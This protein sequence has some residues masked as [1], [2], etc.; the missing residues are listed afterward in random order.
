MA[1]KIRQEVITAMCCPR[2]GSE[3]T[4]DNILSE[5]N[6]QFIKTTYENGNLDEV[7]T[8]AKMVSDQLPQ[9]VISG[10]T[11]ALATS[12]TSIVEEKM[13]TSISTLTTLSNMLSQL[14]Q[15]VPEGIK[16]ELVTVVSKL[17][18]LDDS[19]SKSSQS[20]LQTFNELINKPSSKGRVAEKT[21]SQAWQLTYTNDLID[22]KGGPGKTDFLVTPMVKE[23]Y[24]AKITIERKTGNQKYNLKHIK[25]AINHAKDEGVRYAMLV[26]DCSEQNL[27][28]IFG[29]LFIDKIEG[30][31]VAV[32]D[33]DNSG[34]KMARYVFSVIEYSIIGNEEV[35]EIDVR[36]IGETVKEMCKI[37]EQITLLR[38]KNNAVIQGCEAIR[39]IVNTLEQMFEKYIE[40]LR[41][42]LD[43]IH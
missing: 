43:E 41:S 5:Q 26:Y 1:S 21:L 25:E 9:L 32:T 27:P 16:A 18:K 22:E 14:L 3:I 13:E 20:V 2:C 42:E 38:K 7:I 40:K 23:R 39:D 37:T 24:L 12:L 29:P 28:E 19:T 33:N 34:W 31:T 15:K 6:R 30:I 35:Q 36:K 4:F 8:I 11:K 10:E 17:E